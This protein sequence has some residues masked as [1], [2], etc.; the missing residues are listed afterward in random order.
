MLNP[1]PDSMA[2]DADHRAA[3]RFDTALTVDLEG[4]HGRTRNI[5]AT[6][7]YFETNVDLP[8]GRLLNMNVQFTHCGRKHWLACEGK[9]VRVMP[10]DGLHGVAARLLTPFFSPVQERHTASAAAR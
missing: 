2:R 7:V 10:G 5:S 6:G 4:S 9:V 1:F 8:L 3:D